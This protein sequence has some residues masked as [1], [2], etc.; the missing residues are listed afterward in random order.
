MNETFWVNLEFRLFQSLVNFETGETVNCTPPEVARLSLL[1]LN[2]AKN[3]E[4]TLGKVLENSFG[5]FTYKNQRVL[6][7]LSRPLIIRLSKVH[8]MS[9]S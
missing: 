2:L 9:Y 7:R 5:V 8:S 6:F 4:S 1:E 3:P